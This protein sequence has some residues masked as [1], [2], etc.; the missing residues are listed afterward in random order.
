LHWLNKRTLKNLEDVKDYNKSV[1]DEALPPGIS[2][3]RIHV[4][5]IKNNGLLFGVCSKRVKEALEST[6]F[7]D[8]AM[9]S[10]N[11]CGYVTNRGGMV[12]TSARIKQGDIIKMLVNLSQG[13]ITW[14]CNDVQVAVADMGPLNKE[15]V[16]PFIG[17]GYFGDEV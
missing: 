16:F 17:L 9:I 15:D 7:N 1:G 2:K 12:M 5:S 6:T 13:V 11:S 14:S 8:Q 10:I 3:M 4:H